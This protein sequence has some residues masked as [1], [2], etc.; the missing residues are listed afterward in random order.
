MQDLSCIAQHS[1]FKFIEVTG[2]FTYVDV[3]KVHTSHLYI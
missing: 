2:H 1:I 3:V